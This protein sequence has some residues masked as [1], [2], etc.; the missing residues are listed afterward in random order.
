MSRIGNFIKTRPVIA[1]LLGGAVLLAGVGAV[2]AQYGGG[3]GGP[4]GW[5]RGGGMGGHG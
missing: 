3:M 2:S 4:G 1:T 5:H